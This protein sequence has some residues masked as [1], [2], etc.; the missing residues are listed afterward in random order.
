MKREAVSLSVIL[1]LAAGVGACTRQTSEPPAEATRDTAPPATEPRETA[2]EAGRATSDAWITTK[3][4]S[5]FFG[6]RVVKARD[7]DVSTNNGTVTLMG[8]VDSTEEKSRAEQVAMQTE[9]VRSVDNQL[10]VG[11][12]EV[13]RGRENARGTAVGSAWITAKV[14][15][16]YF[17]E[18]QLRGSDIDVDTNAGVV[19]IA[20]TVPSQQAR[21]RALAIARATDGVRQV[22]DQLRVSTEPRGTSGTAGEPPRADRGEPDGRADDGSITMRIQSRYFSDEEVRGR[23]I[24]V[25]TVNGRVRLQ[26]E[27]G[28]EAERQQAIRLARSTP[29]VV[30]VDDQLKVV[31]DKA[32]RTDRARAARD[33]QPIEDAWI[34]TKIQ[35]KYFIDR[36]VAATAID[37]TTKG[38]VVTLTGRVDTHEAKRKAVEIARGTV[39]VRQVIDRLAVDSP[40]AEPTARR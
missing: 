26:G 38:G 24:D 23:N 40:G 10:V 3:I 13:A 9:G 29:G 27:V 21:E 36:M 14:Q 1:V 28:S 16:Q 39:G 37:V 12:R 34:T 18:S 35:S 20:G 4:Q 30:D 11:P 15:A 2:R 22:D 33:G 8:R 32:D 17:T 31:A 5:Q 7:I 25:D 19:T 6:D